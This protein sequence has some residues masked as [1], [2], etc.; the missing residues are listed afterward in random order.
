MLNVSFKRKEKSS[1][2]QQ[3]AINKLGLIRGKFMS[4]HEKL[5]RF[6]AHDNFSGGFDPAKVL[7]AFEAPRTP[8][9]IP[10]H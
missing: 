4:G 9:T 10:K 7:N 5:I 2:A 3:I 6:E 1:A 8:T